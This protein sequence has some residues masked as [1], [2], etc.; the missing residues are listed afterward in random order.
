MKQISKRH[1]TDYKS[2]LDKR[3]MKNIGNSLL[4]IKN[5]LLYEEKSEA[6]CD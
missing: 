2:Y 4:Q 3:M 6:I 1:Q 5:Q